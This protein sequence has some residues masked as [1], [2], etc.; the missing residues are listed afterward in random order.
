MHYKN[1]PQYHWNSCS[2]LN[3]LGSSISKEA[4][5]EAMADFVLYTFNLKELYTCTCTHVY[6]STYMYMYMYMLWS[7]IILST[8]TVEPWQ[9]FPEWTLQPPSS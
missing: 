5:C 3:N 9:Q 4:L 6:M 1:K 7:H 2:E 8:Q